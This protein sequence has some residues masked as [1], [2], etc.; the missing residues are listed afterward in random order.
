L[1][2][3]TLSEFLGPPLTDEM[4]CRMSKGQGVGESGIVKIVL[5]PFTIV[6]LYQEPSCFDPGKPAQLD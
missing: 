1:S 3:T 5:W 2:R 4:F 6:A